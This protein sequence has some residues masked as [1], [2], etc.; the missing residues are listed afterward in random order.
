VRYVILGEL[1][2]LYYHDK[3]LK[4]FD[5]MIGDS[6]DLVYQY[7]NLDPKI[8]IYYRAPQNGGT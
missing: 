2:R 8:K 5:E 6:L 3:G 1:E 7:P 4:K